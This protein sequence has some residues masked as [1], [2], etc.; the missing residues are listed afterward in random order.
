VSL[1][2]ALEE[3]EYKPQEQDP[4]KDARKMAEQGASF[5]GNIPKQMTGGLA[6]FGG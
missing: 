2:L 5:F 3:K 4:D 6:P 1:T